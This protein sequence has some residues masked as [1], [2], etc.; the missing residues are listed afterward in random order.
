MF[1]TSFMRAPAPTAPSSR[2]RLAIRPKASPQC[3]NSAASPAARMMSCP[4]MAGFLLPDTGACGSKHGAWRAAMI[5]FRNDLF[6]P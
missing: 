2:L 5:L 1:T 4:S 3:A 6:Q